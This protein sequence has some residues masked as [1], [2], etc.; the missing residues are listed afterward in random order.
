MNIS[1][2]CEF[3]KILCCEQVPYYGDW[4][5]RK[6]LGGDRRLI[7]EKIFAIDTSVLIRSCK[8]QKKNYDGQQN[9]EIM[10]VFFH[11]DFLLHRSVHSSCMLTIVELYNDSM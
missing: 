6:H 3:M 1:D 7:C 8:N 11:T 2:I 5:K 4:H 10:N 9:L